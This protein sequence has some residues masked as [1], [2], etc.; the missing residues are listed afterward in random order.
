MKKVKVNTLNKCEYIAQGYTTGLSDIV[1]TVRKP[2][3]SVFTPAPTVVEDQNGA[4]RYEYTPDLVG[5]WQERVVSASNGDEVIRSYWVVAT[6]I[7]DV[8]SQTDSIE[9]K[10]DAVDSKVDN[11]QNTVDSV[12]TKVDTVDGKVDT[13]DGKVDGVDS[14]VDGVQ[15][16]ADSVEGKVDNLQSSVDD[17]PNQITFP[18]GGYFSA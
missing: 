2:D 4:Y 18:K 6:D 8:K 16:T 11:V 7:D 17:L 15:A 12:E 14:K 10:V 3:G 13:V 9:S 5:L 1:V